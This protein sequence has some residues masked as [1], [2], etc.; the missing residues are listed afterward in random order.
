M[1]RRNRDAGE[2]TPRQTEIALLYVAGFARA[3]IASSLC[4]ERD[5]VDASIART[6]VD[7]G[8]NRKARL[9][10]IMTARLEASA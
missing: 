10:Q 3:Y 5:T 1:P 7:L 6:Y 4:I 8:I 9:R 2:I